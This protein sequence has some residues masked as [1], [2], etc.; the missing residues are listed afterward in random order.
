MREINVEDF[1]DKLIYVD[2][3]DKGD[4]EN[5]QDLFNCKIKVDIEKHNQ[6]QYTYYYE[7]DFGDDRALHVEIESGI[8]NG[9]RINHE[10]WDVSSKPDSRTV[11]VLK[12]IVLDKDMYNDPFIMK[13][14]QAVL[15]ANK[16]KLFEFHR[17][18]SYDNYVTGG[19]SRMKMDS[20]LASLHLKY[21]YE[22]QE[23]DI[24]W[25]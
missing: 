5:L 19:N 3:E 13:K 14:A 1:L 11:E 21:I 23:V 10:E 2:P 6:L 17:Q 20:L 22:E 15:N 9:T 8:N 7:I 4:I 25:V 12:D 24:N 18:N 16:G